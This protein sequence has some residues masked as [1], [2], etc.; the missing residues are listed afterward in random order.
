MKKNLILILLLFTSV[1]YGQSLFPIPFEGCIT[2]RFLLEKDTIVAKIDNEKLLQVFSE[3]LGSKMMK[4]IHGKIFL[5]FVVDTTGI[6]CLQSMLN[7]TN[8]SDK[9]L[10]VLKPV[11]DNELKWSKITDKIAAIVQI[12][13][14]ETHNIEL[15]RFGLDGYAGLRE[16]SSK[17]L[18]VVK[19]PSAREKNTNTSN[20]PEIVKEIS[21]KSIWKHYTTANSLLVNNFVRKIDFQTDGSAWFCTDY[22]VVCSKNDIWER[23]DNTNTPFPANDYGNVWTTQLFV[24]NTDRVWV[25]ASNKYYIFDG[26]SWLPADSVYKVRFQEMGILENKSLNLITKETNGNI[27]LSTYS[28]GG[29]K[30]ILYKDNRFTIFSF[31]DDSKVNAVPRYIRAICT[32]P[33]NIIWLATDS[34]LIKVANKQVTV[35]NTQNSGLPSNSVSDVVLDNSGNLWVATNTEKN[36]GG[37]VRIDSEGNWKLYNTSNSVLPDNTVWSI[38]KDNNVLW[39]CMHSGGIVRI[40]NDKF[41]TGFEALGNSS[42]FDLQVDKSGN[43]WVGTNRGLFISN[44]K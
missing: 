6:S 20:K 16:I 26:R 7:K 8:Y 9:K 27:W 33:N 2:D 10:A 3:A 31:G 41:K 22:G 12:T 19:I 21:D 14:S 29:E 44:V 36:N 42:V 23:F 11:M 40:E 13:I 24:D 34:G 17:P 30:I 18:P 25:N 38:I 43:K 15:K 37:L 32:T 4:T 35:Y 1:S 39:L 5:Q 28:N